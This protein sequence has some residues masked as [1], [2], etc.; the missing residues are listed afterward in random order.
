MMTRKEECKNKEI[1]DKR[2]MAMVIV[3]V[4]NLGTRER[5]RERERER[6]AED[7]MVGEISRER[8]R[9]WCPWK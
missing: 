6:D 5:E 3:V 7:Y 8:E 1:R 2:E 9:T 4:E